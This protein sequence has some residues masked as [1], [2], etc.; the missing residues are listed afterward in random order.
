M[1][2]KRLSGAG[3]RK[4]SLEKTR[5]LEDVLSKTKKINDFF[6]ITSPET[7]VNLTD[8]GKILLVNKN[9]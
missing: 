5:N 2:R 3:C 8:L 1:N 6:S 7:G 4:I 9:L